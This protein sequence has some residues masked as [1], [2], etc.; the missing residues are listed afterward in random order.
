[1]ALITYI[2]QACGQPELV[3]DVRTGLLLLWDA[4]T[5]EVFPLIAGGGGGDVEPS[6]PSPEELELTRAQTEATRQQTEIGRQQ[7]ELARGQQAEFEAL[8]PFIYEQYGLTRTVGEGGEITLEPTPEYAEQRAMAREIESLQ[9]ERSLAALKGELP[10]TETLK[11]ELEYG[12]QALN[13]RLSRQLGPGYETSTPGIQALAEFQR[14]GTSLKEAEQ[15]QQL[16]TAEAL[17]LNRQTSRTG[18][19]GA[20][21]QG[22][23]Y[24]AGTIANLYGQSAG[25]YGAAGRTAAQG[26]SLLAENRY[27]GAYYRE[28]SNRRQSGFVSDLIG[29]AIAGG[30]MGFAAYKSHPKYKQHIEPVSDMSMLAALREIPVYK[31]EYKTDGVPHIGGMTPDMPDEVTTADRSGYDVVSYLGLLTGSIRALD[32]EVRKLTPLQALR[33]AA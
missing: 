12:R 1:M 17:A 21:Q 33:A 13:E 20:V 31:W 4:D 26:A 22:S 9:N 16:S 23:A 32:R 27:Q 3:R 5:R 2:E 29:G 15:H 28:Q 7:L 25:T 18:Y 8:S 24:P 10:V 30:A 6:T 19:A 11:K 14:M